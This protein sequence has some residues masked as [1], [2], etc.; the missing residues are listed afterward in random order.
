MIK[1][2]ISVEPFEAIARTLPL[3]SVAVQADPTEQG[4]RHVWLEE[5]WVNRLRAMRR[6]GE[7]YS[8]VILRLANLDARNSFLA[9][10]TGPARG[11]KR[12]SNSERTTVS[13]A[14]ASTASVT[15]ACSPEQFERTTS[16]APA[17]RSPRRTTPPSVRAPRPTARPKTFR[18]RAAARVAAAG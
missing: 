1:I 4:Q 5:V 16:S 7:S 13:M 3:D 14:R 18:P 9:A 15:T 6:P 10:E 8:D 2:A 17:K 11:N 12:G